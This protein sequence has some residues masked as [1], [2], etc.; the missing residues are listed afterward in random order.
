[1]SREITDMVHHQFHWS[2]PWLAI[3]YSNWE[4][5]MAERDRLLQ[6]IA[7]IIADYRTGQIPKPDSA[8]VERWINQFDNPV[9]LPM[10]TE[11][12]HV[13]G[14]TYFSRDAVTKFLSVVAKNA[15]LTGGDPS[16]FWRGVCFLDI[17][18]RGSSQ[19]D[20][21]AIFQEVL[22]KEFGLKLSD[23]GKI[24]HTYL[25]LDDALFSGGHI[26]SDLKT[27]ISNAAPAEAKLSVVTIAFHTQGQFFANNNLNDA[28]AKAGKKISI[29]WWRAIEVEDRKGK[30]SQFL[31]ASDVL[32][33]TAIPNDPAT[34]AYM[35][36]LGIQPDFRVPGNVGGL[37]LFS[38]EPGRHML[39][40]EFLKMGVRIRSMCPHLNAYQRP[41]GNTLQRKAGF[42][43]MLVTFRNCPNNA[44]LVLWA[45]NPWYPLFPRSTN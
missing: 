19:K 23:C 20:L 33:P 8:H 30:S 6:S 31:N 17:Q 11:L 21:L 32:R 36:A 13:L 29:A 3:R 25:Y 5:M 12:E 2:L 43:S 39:E 4:N 37:K 41:L 35:N 27:W 28:M 15:Q 42:G 26:E 24:P 44:P 18:Q 22:L 16:T 38:S 1:M 7:D 14:K 10:L 34:V 40:Q 45:G 9:Q